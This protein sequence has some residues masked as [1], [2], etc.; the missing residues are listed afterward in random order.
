M[1]KGFVCPRLKEKISIEA[2]LRDCPGTERCHPV[3]VLLSLISHR[4]PEDG[5]YHV[6][7]LLNPPRV[8]YLERHY[9]YYAPPE[10]LIYLVF[11]S[12]LHAFLEL[13]AKDFDRYEISPEDYIIERPMPPYEIETP[14]GKGTIVGRPDL[15]VTKAQTLYDYKTIKYYYTGKKMLAGD[16]QDNTYMWQLNAY[17]VFAYPEAKRLV[18]EAFFKDFDNKMSFLGLSPLTA[19]NVPMLPKEQVISRFREALSIQLE[20]EQKKA[21]PRPCTPEETWDGRR[22]SAYC[23]V[24]PFCPEGQEKIIPIGE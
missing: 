24:L 13:D 17:R 10:S 4:T 8:V 3:P 14:Y 16:W 12:A 20:H 11:G 6:T 2:C 5:V 9:D 22:C 23:H 15:Y 1:L 18:L 19:I 21:V 7:E